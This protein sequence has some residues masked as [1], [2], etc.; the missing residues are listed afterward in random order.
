MGNVFAEGRSE[1]A[2]S[3][4]EQPIENLGPGRLD[5]A[6]GDGVSLVALGPGS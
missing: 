1:V 5:P 2:L 3:E 6:L 4:N